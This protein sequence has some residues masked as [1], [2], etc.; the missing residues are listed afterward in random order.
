MLNEGLRNLC[1]SRRDFIFAA[2]AALMGVVGFYVSRNNF[3]ASEWHRLGNHD[4]CQRDATRDSSASAEICAASVSSLRRN[5][6][7]N[8]F[9]ARSFAMSVLY[10][11]F[12]AV[13][14]VT[15]PCPNCF[16]RA[17]R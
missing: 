1:K 11:V 13:L 8:L 3:S 17:P 15:E 4:L 10:Q 2:Q 9:H 14:G 6:C 12:E 7:K 16:S 5:R